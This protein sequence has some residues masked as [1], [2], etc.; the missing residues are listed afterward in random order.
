MFDYRV[1]LDR[2]ELRHQGPV[3][4]DR[5]QEKRPPLQPIPEN[6]QAHISHL[7]QQKNNIYSKVNP[8]PNCN[9]GDLTSQRSE[10]SQV[11]NGILFLDNSR[12]MIRPTGM[13]TPPPPM[14]GDV[15]EEDLWDPKEIFYDA[16]QAQAEHMR[17][18]LK[19]QKLIEPPSVRRQK[20][21]IS[22]NSNSKQPKLKAKVVYEYSYSDN[23]DENGS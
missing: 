7:D 13:K 2:R 19:Q 21:P 1:K 18:K 14:W 12:R 15:I 4:H 16:Q 22:Q 20:P 10:L 5:M 6:Q 9:R 8:S 23:E 3:S 17:R 11:D